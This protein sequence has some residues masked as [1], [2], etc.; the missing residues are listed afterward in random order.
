[1]LDDC[2]NTKSLIESMLCLPICTSTPFCWKTKVSTFQFVCFYYKSLSRYTYNTF[3]H[4]CV[5]QRVQCE[6]ITQYIDKMNGLETSFI[7]M[8]FYNYMPCRFNK[9]IIK[10]SIYRLW[11][12]PGFTSKTHVSHL[13]SYHFASTQFL[14]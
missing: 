2:V 1:M 3:F 7:S 5:T 4:Q 8:L 13:N 10:N 9:L 6:H 14:H 12:H 11:R